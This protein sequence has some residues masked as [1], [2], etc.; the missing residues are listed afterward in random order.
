MNAIQ[1]EL[2][3]LA[4]LLGLLLGGCG[5]PRAYSPDPGPYDRIPAAWDE[6]LFEARR[7]LDEGEPD[8]AHEILVRLAEENPRILPV[9]IFLQELELDLLLERGR[10]G[11]LSFRDLERVQE[12]LG[13]HYLTKAEANPTPE[14][15]VLAARLEKDYSKALELLNQAEALDPDCVWIPYARAWWNFTDY[16]FT[17]AEDAVREAFRIDS[18]HLA[19]MRLHGLMLTSAGETGGALKVLEQWWKRSRNDPL[20]SPER[21]GAALFDL[22]SLHVLAGEP[23][24]ALRLLKDVDQRVLDEVARIEEVRAAA[25][26]GLDDFPRSHE[27][28]RRA[29]ELDPDDP[30]PLVQEA[31]LFARQRDEQAELAAWQRL[32]DHLDTTEDGG[33]GTMVYRLQALTRL[34]RAE[35]EEREAAL[36]AAEADASPDEA[37]GRGEA[38][39]TPRP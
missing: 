13:N 24:E 14:G 18:G 4:L 19:T 16:H 6:P 34:Q 23:R 37:A 1:S 2:R 36:A 27:A 30:L 26:E 25:H 39:A 28:V 3:R 38:E 29:R 10:A 12:Y 32:L 33:F 9:R 22:A 35:R 20:V 17:S 7:Y 8:R 21:L 5:A 11:R 15:F 31:M